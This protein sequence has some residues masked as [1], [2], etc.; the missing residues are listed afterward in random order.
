[1]V[2]F[3]WTVLCVVYE[4]SR[5]VCIVVRSD[6]SGRT[7]LRDYER[8]GIGCQMVH[9]SLELSGVRSGLSDHVG[10]LSRCRLLGSVYLRTVRR[11][12]LDGPRGA[13][14]V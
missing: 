4:L 8:S 5:R 11:N 1:M 2:R 12:V 14:M 7:T 6:G 10:V 9:D 3:D 13:W